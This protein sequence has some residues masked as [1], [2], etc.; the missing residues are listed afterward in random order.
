MTVSPLSQSVSSSFNQNYNWD[1]Q[2]LAGLGSRGHHRE[3][4]ELIIGGEIRKHPEPHH[5][6][7]RIEIKN[8]H[9]RVQMVRKI[10]VQ[11]YNEY[12]NSIYKM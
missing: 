4:T 6:N 8:K 2:T 12:Q 5:G 1:S 7:Q 11:F 10:A 9:T 3:E